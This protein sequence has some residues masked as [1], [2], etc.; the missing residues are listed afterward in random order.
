MQTED[1]KWT[2]II[3]FIC[4]GGWAI[5]RF[6]TRPTDITNQVKEQPVTS[7]V[8]I[9]D[10]YSLEPLKEDR[11]FCALESNEY[12]VVVSKNNLKDTIY[13]LYY[14]YILTIPRDSLIGTFKNK[15]DCF[16]KMNY[17]IKD[18]DSWRL[19]RYEVVKILTEKQITGSNY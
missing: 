6:I 9:P 3:V 13:S 8:K 1:I 2:I 10:S 17:L 14:R 5:Y 11:D 18:R 4:I 12:Y 16:M 7:S 15:K 19:S